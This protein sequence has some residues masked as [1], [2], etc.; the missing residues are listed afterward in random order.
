MSLGTDFLRSLMLK[1]LL[2]SLSGLFLI[3]FLVG[4]LLGNLQ[5]LV[6]ND[7][8]VARLQFNAY[9][10]FM[11]T[12]PVVKFLSYLTYLFFL[13]HIVYAIVITR[14]NAAARPQD[15]GC[16]RNRGGQASWASKNMGILGTV[17]LIFLVIHLRGFWYEMHWGGILLDTEGQKDLY[18]VVVKAYAQWWYVLIY[19]VSMVF[20]AYHLSHGFGS[21]FQTLGLYHKRYTP[22]IQAFGIAFSVIVSGLFALIPIV[23][24]LRIL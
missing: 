12:N 22:M 24:Y 20:L 21:V 9:A 14:L 1:K 17:I 18:S 10:Q 8:G 4:H 15:Y 11:T 6:S 16:G 3:L 19:V 5:L 13:L 7:G 23:M 2:V